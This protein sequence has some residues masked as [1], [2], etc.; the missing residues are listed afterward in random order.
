[1]QPEELSKSELIGIH[2]DNEV[3]LTKNEDVPK[4]V[5]LAEKLHMKGILC[6]G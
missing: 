5:T 4:D 1:M 3:A 6:D 2:E